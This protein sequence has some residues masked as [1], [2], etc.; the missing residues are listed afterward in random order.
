MTH[1]ATLTIIGITLAI[2]VAAGVLAALGPSIA[3]VAVLSACTLLFLDMTFHLSGVFQRLP[4][5]SRRRVTRD[6]RRVADIHRIKAALEQYVAQV[7]PLPTAEEY[8][9][10]TGPA[11]FWTNWWDF[12]SHDGDGD[13]A[14]F[15]DFLIEADILSTV[16]LD[17]MNT[18]SRTADV[19]GGKEYVY[20]VVPA[21]YD[22]A[23]GTCDARP[24][25]WHYM[26]AITDLE[27][28]TSRPPKRV[29]G[30]GCDCLW[31]DRP[32]LFQQ[33]FDYVVCGS[34]D[35]T[36]AS[37]ARAAE[38]RRKRVAAKLAAQQAAQQAAADLAAKRAAAVVAE[39][40]A[41]ELRKYVPQ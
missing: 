2:A 20:F 8:G 36:P 7:G 34:F 3:R 18:P 35:A 28:E 19:G 39:K 22:Y 24:N 38:T 11:G 41:A 31:R 12:S 1:R 9:E 27:E 33:Y 40:R 23:G 16:P 29:R 5:A 30:S 10:A 21:G 32:N 13:R 25:R 14:P 6:E 15:L 17:P 37:R 26:L 4:P